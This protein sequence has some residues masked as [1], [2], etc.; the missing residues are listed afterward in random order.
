MNSPFYCLIV[1][2]IEDFASGL[3]YRN[4]LNLVNHT[5]LKYILLF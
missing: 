5:L 3:F 2:R 4:H 1:A